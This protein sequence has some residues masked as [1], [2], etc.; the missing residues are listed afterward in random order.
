MRYSNLRTSWAALAGFGLVALASTVTVAAATLTAASLSGWT[1]YASA[2]EQ[3]IARELHGH[4]PFLALD[5]AA[6]AATARRTLLG[7]GIV[8]EEMNTRGH[9]GAAIEVPV[10]DTYQGEADMCVP[11]A[12]ADAAPVTWVPGATSVGRMRPSFAGPRLDETQRP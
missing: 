4:G 3:R 6:T 2:T 11:E 1:R 12:Q 7:G 5:Y 8:I 10:D 9:D